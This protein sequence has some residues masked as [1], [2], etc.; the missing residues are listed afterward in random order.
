MFFFQTFR[1]IL[2]D[3]ILNIFYFPVWW[4]TTGV[5][6]VLNLINKEISSL[7]GAL[8]LKTLFRFLFKPMFGLTDRWSLVISIG[9]RLV[10]FFVLSLVTLL[11]TVVLVLLFLL[12]LIL[13]FFILYNILFHAGVKLDFMNLY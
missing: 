6:K 12:W 2:V 8:R 3:L 7:A 11:Y 5:L 13:P 9:V 1:F 4:Y 10:H